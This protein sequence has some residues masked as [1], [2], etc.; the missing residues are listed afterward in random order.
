MG[1]RKAA[2]PHV[3][4]RERQVNGHVRKWSTHSWFANGGV[5]CLVT[6]ED[7]TYFDKLKGSLRP[8]LAAEA[9]FSTPMLGQ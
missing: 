5:H 9:L 7:M 4:H 2:E 6:M 1:T 8:P 3:H